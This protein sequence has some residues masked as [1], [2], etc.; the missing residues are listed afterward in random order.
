MTHEA[1]PFGA[2]SRSSPPEMVEDV[3]SRA[4]I[5]CAHPDDAEI[6]VGATVAKWTGQGC[7]ITYVVCTT[8]SGGSND[9]SM[10]AERLVLLRGQE[11]HDSAGALGVKEVVMLT[12]PDGSLEDTYEFR[13]EVVRAIRK[14]RPHTVFTHDPYRMSGFQHRDHRMCG[15]VTMDAVYPFARD[16][17]H[18]PEQIKSEGL[19]PHKVR[20]L[21]MW[22][23]DRPDVV[24][25]VT[26][27]IEQQIE[28]LSRHT[29]QVGGLAPEGRLGARMR[30]RAEATAD[31]L[32]FRYGQAFRR[33]VARG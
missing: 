5:V 11:Q 12:H 33:L 32:P 31:G 22:G 21:M 27:T 15:I 30:E 14:Y 19:L 9:L 24:V 4:L 8:G 13:G 26:D 2:Q 29:S 10:T 16:H 18:F 3:P 7:E 6:G 17:L 20:H 28:A 23:S 25:D 1:S